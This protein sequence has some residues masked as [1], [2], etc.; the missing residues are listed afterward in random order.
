MAQSHSAGAKLVIHDAE[1]PPLPDETGI[2]LQPNTASTLAIKQ[3]TEILESESIRAFH[4]R[5]FRRW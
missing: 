5:T 3:V 2:D 1:S 4:S